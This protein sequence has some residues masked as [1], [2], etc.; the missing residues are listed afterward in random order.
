MDERTPSF[1]Q[2]IEN[3]KKILN[4]IFQFFKN[5]QYSKIFERIPLGILLIAIFYYVYN[6]SYLSI[7]A[8]DIFSTGTHDVGIYDQIIWLF[9]RFLPPLNTLGGDLLF[10]FHVSLNCVLL[11]PLFWIWSNIYMLYIAQSFFLGLAVIPLFLYA[12]NKLQNSY[13]ALAVGLSFLMYPALQNMNLENFH[14]ETLTIFS[15]SFA[16]YFML[17]KNFR[18]YYPFLFL[19]LLGKEEMGIVAIFMGLYLVFFEKQKKNGLITLVIGVIWSLLC[20]KVIM[21]LANGINIFS[22]SQPLVYSHWFGAFINNI[23][24]PIYYLNNFFAL[25]SLT[26]LRHLFE[27][28]LF[29]P[30]LSPATLLMALPALAINILS[31]VGYL[32][33][34]YYHY[35][36][37]TT[38]F[39]FFALVN[40]IYRIKHFNF[41]RFY[42]K[43]GVLVLIG[44]SLV[45]VGFLENS[46]LGRV[47]IRRYQ[48]AIRI[49]RAEAYGSRVSAKRKALKLIPPEAKVSAS[50]S[51]FPH[52][53]HRKEIYMFSN[54][55]SPVY[56]NE[57]VPR[58]PALEHA[59]YVA[60]EGVN[61]GGEEEQMIIRYL[62]RSAFY[63]VIYR[64]DSLRILK[65][66]DRYKEGKN[67]GA[68]FV[69]YDLDK[70][71]SIVDDFSSKLKVKQAGRLSM[72]YFPSSNYEFKNLLGQALPVAKQMALE[73]YGYIF[74]PE[75]GKYGF[76][77]KTN[78]QARLELD[79]KI[80]DSQVY[81]RRGFHSYKIKYL[82][83]GQSYDLR[84]IVIPPQGH[85]YII[86]D[87]DLMKRYN[88]TQFRNVLRKYEE[89]RRIRENFLRNQPNRI[90]N[91]GFE[92]VYGNK[93]RDWEIEHWLAESADCSYVLSSKI[94][95]K[96]KYSAII[97]HKGLADSRWVQ[98]IEV[99]PVT[100]YKLSGWIKTVGIKNKGAGAFLVVDD[101][102]M[103]TQ[104]IRG[105]QNWQY[106]QVTGKTRPDQDKVKV[107][108]RL[109]YYGAPNEGKAF[110]DQIEFLEILP[111]QTY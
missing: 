36:Y 3:Y 37:V 98:E 71:V 65:R 17:T 35:N 26:Y 94:R 83:K 86:S 72:L 57:K 90:V 41:K 88:S 11:A 101:M 110:F 29:I 66:N 40:G 67:S 61:H 32:R 104:E 92:K 79:G 87:R 42:L 34:V 53:S 31:G 5:P 58:P 24:N 1:S 109:G 9:S 12:K 93:P 21:P 6:L 20:F 102:G 99:N 85:K 105:T 30:L 56:W 22:S 75:N 107:Q 14:P 10:A 96:G 55:F 89:R 33:S 54:P 13:L 97:K 28:V 68:N 46:M 60:I 27:P 50:Y 78:G 63:K 16:A 111:T 106:V 74:I 70:N 44:L 80:I 73:I 64:E 2:T 47:P 15:L 19:S 49:G 82:N 23:F 48:E 8:H 95:R 18:F 51:L 108:C 84:L 7:L 91:G 4:S 38:C 62:S 76:D 45:V 59:D 52:L 103:K 25:D 39:I 81:L 69:L 77:L 100:N 43:Q